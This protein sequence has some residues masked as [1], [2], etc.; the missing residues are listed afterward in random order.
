ME[1]DLNK[2]LHSVCFGL[3]KD[4]HENYESYMYV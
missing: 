1:D 2:I 4:S 3:K